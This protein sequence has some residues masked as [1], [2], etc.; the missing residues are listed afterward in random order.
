MIQSLS[1][2]AVPNY[3]MNGEARTSEAGLDKRGAVTYNFPYQWT[4]DIRLSPVVL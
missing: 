2:Q 1:S 3:I 4:P